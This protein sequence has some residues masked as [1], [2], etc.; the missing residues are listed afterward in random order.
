MDSKFRFNFQVFFMVETY[1]LSRKLFLPRR[2]RKSICLDYYA[3]F[4]NTTN[5]G[6]YMGMETIFKCT[7]LINVFYTIWC[8]NPYTY[9]QI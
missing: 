5:I 1:K 3:L 2:T 8:R 9:E 6:T 7:D 4:T